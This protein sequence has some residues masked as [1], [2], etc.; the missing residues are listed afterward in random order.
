M[1]D[2]SKKDTNQGEGDRE[3]A[4]RYNEAT[5]EFVESGEMEKAPDPSHQ[6]EEA[7]RNAEEEGKS[8][9]KELDPEIHRDYDEATKD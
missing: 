6:S 5:K 1:S 3:A 8:R 2:N 4:K 9:A 7:A